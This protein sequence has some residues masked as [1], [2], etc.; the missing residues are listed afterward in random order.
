MEINLIA[1]QPRLLDIESKARWWDQIWHDVSHNL[2]P[3]KVGIASV[4]H[5]EAVGY[6]TG[7]ER[8]EYVSKLY[9]FINDLKVSAGYIILLGDESNVDAIR[10]M[11][12]FMILMDGVRNLPQWKYF[13]AILNN[14]EPDLSVQGTETVKQLPDV[15]GVTLPSL[16]WEVECWVSEYVMKRYG[17][18]LGWKGD[19]MILD[20]NFNVEECSDENE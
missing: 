6:I 18:E 19:R 7:A 12:G 16:R 13:T 17:L 1:D 2:V 10:K 4:N 5:A 14:E 20:Y 9:P 3:A 15:N 11:L 8:T